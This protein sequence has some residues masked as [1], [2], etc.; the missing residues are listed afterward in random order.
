[1]TQVASRFPEVP[2]RPAVYAMYGGEP[3]RT[4][5]A[6]VGTA[7]DLNR[8]LVQ[9]FVNRDSSVVTG[10]SAAGINID[11]VRYVEWWEDPRFEDPDVRHAAELVAF[12]VLDPALRSRGNPRQAAKE[13]YDD[14]EFNASM[15]QLF[16]RS[17]DGRFAPP[18]VW[19]LAE[20]LSQVE[21]RVQQLERLADDLRR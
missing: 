16:R 6:Y 9:H 20:R 8:R 4:W 21:A 15:A 3:P 17:A 2:K 13:H 1:V 14:L 11:A 12:E 10:T 19:D 18:R 7:G 5:V